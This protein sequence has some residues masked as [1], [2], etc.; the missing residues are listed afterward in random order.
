MM[1]PIAV[2]RN[3]RLIDRIS[4][5]KIRDQDVEGRAALR[6]TSIAG[7]RFGAEDADVLTAGSGARLKVV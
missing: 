5:C 2:S 7:V 6:P 4:R 1:L 3:V